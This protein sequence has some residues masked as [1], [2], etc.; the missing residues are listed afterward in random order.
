MDV[1]PD[2]AIAEANR[3]SLLQKWQGGMARIWDYTPS[4][5][6][7]TI[8]VTFKDLEGSLYIVCGQCQHI[9]GPFFWENCTFERHQRMESGDE[10]VQVLQDAGVGFELR[11]MVISEVEGSE[12]EHIVSGY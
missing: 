9:T 6:R 1:K 8:R 12:P 5:S 7:M 2:P 3:H 4:L 11:C 10:V